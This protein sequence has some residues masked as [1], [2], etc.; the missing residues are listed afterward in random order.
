MEDLSR[1]AG[2]EWDVGNVRKSL[3]K[4]GVQSAEAEQLFFNDPL[5]VSDDIAHSAAEWRFQALGKT[6]AGRLLFAAFTLRVNGTLIRP[7]S[8][9]DMNAKERLRYGKET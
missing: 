6:N 8:V 1:I 7:I 4:N 5:L 9:R 2:F 3:T